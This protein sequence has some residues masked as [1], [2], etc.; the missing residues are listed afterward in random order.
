MK[1]ILNKHLQSQVSDSFTE[2]KEPIGILLFRGTDL[3]CEYCQQTEQLLKEVAVLSD[4]L[5]LKIFNT[6]ALDDPVI[7]FRIENLP[8]VV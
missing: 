2:L 7:N 4:K 3:E 1:G 5:E 8:T 6:G